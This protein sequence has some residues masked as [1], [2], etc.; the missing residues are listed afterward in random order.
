MFTSNYIYDG[1]FVTS[2]S[3]LSDLGQALS[4]FV[5]VLFI[6]FKCHKEKKIEF[7]QLA[8][9]TNSVFCFISVLIL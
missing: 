7:Q 5:L 6:V 3:L 9:N 1:V 8:K 2:I 4:S